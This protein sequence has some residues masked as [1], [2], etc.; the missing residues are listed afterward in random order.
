MAVESE[1]V[2][3]RRGLQVGLLAEDLERL[4]TCG[5]DTYGTLSMASAGQPGQV[6]DERFTSSVVEK[7][8]PGEAI[9][10]LPSLKRLYLE[11]YSACLV[12]MKRTVEQPG[13][14][15]APKVPEVEKRSRLAN[16]MRDF[17][18]A[19]VSGIYEPASSLV[20]EFIHMVRT[21]SVKFIDWPKLLSREDE[22]KAKKQTT[23]KSAAVKWEANSTGLVALADLGQDRAETNLTSDY[24]VRCALHRR[25]VAMHIA[26]LCDFLAHEQVVDTYFE[27]KHDPV[28]NGYRAITMDQVKMTDEA[29]WNIWQSVP[30]EGPH[31][32][33][34]QSSLFHPPCLRSSSVLMW[35]CISDHCLCLCHQMWHVPLRLPLPL[36]P[37]RRRSARFLI[38]AQTTRRSPNFPWMGCPSASLST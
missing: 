27:R 17:P 34:L 7:I 14:E 4:T 33:G 25:S 8:L 36:R 13:E 29:V 31:R 18:G 15:S 3:K 23:L 30:E 2:L 12:D 28:P 1:A 37:S 35:S 19:K 32:Q 26:G 21:G 16:F 22:V 38:L 5:W 6:A 11:A 9:V 10:R 20:D 24:L